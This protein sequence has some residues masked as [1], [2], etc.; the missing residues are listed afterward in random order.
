MKKIYLPLI[1]LAAGFAT[2]FIAAGVHSLFFGLVPIIAFALGYFSSWR[3]GLL[4]GSLLFISYTFALSLIWW[5]PGSPNLL[6]PLPYLAAFIAGGFSLLIIGTGAPAVRK[7]FR[8]PGSILILVILT[9]VTGWCGYTALPRYSYYYQVAIQSSESLS[10]LELYLPVGTVAGEPHMNL[11]DQ[12]LKMPGDTT[13]NFDHRIVDT[14][15]GKMLKINIP[16]L[17]KDNVPVPR[18]TANIIFWE[19]R[20]FFQK[21]AP[22]RL[23]QLMPK[24]DVVPVNT[25]TSQRFTWPVKTRESLLVERFEVPVRITASSKAPIKLTMWNRT[26]RTEAI[27]FT[28]TFTK[29]DPYTER[30]SYGLQTGNEWVFVPVE[31]TS[32]L[33][34][35]GI[36]D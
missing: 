9:I 32:V 15:R 22:H 28:Y 23:I 29:S 3:W 35:R 27:N 14:D 33:E 30:I 2:G 26:D 6:Y 11:Y 4:C 20:G 24:Y 16:A 17:K 25:A 31:A 21:S 1:A 7:G 5:G 18:Y 36:S 34:I 8:K 19:G 10:N 12:V 13:E